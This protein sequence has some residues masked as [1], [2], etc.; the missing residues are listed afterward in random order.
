V[1]TARYELIFQ[2]NGLRF[3]LDRINIMYQ[4]DASMNQFKMLTS[5]TEDENSEP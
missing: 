5:V 1:F 3:V 2:Y 4:V